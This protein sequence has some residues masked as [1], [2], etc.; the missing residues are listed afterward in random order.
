MVWLIVVF[1]SVTNG[2]EKYWIN[3]FVSLAAPVKVTPT[4]VIIA[5]ITIRLDSISDASNY[6]HKSIAEKRI[7]AT[8]DPYDPDID[9]EVPS[10]WPA[11]DLDAK[12][13]LKDWLAKFLL[14]L[15]QFL[16]LWQRI[17]KRRSAIF[18]CEWPIAPTTALATF[19]VMMEIKPLSLRLR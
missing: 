15:L 2:L 10:R 16:E 19:V 7:A 18:A 1:F 12:G 6:R 4:D 3:K 5:P 14:L 17:M 13:Q 8:L 11:P 9:E